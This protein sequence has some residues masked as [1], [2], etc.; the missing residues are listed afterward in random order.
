M[1]ILS[2]DERYELKNRLIL[3]CKA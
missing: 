1:S 2:D 3:A